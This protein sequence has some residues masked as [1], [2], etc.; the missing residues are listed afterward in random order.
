VPIPAPAP[1]PLPGAIT[2]EIKPEGEIYVDGVLKG[3]SPPL[4]KI[5][6]P[7]GEH[8][9]EIRNGTFKPLVTELSVG[10]GE[11]FA[12]QHNFV[13]AQPPKPPVKTKAPPKPRPQAQSGPPKAA[14]KG[15]WQRFV[16]W[17]DRK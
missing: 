7:A 14:E 6:V 5:Q 12:V 13:A 16:D 11:E 4:K 2:F 10:Q 17:L 15:V 3:K 9:I 8:V 1:E